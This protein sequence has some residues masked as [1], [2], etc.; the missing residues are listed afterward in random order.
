M[1]SETVLSAV[2]IGLLPA[3]TL[4]NGVQERQ[5]FVVGPPNNAVVPVAAA[6]VAPPP[7]NAIVEPV[8]PILSQVPPQAPAPIPAPALPAIPDVPAVPLSVPE[9]PPVP[10]AP[11]LPAPPALPVPPALPA[12]PEVPVAPSVPALPIVGGTGAP[13][14]LDAATNV[15]ANPAQTLPEVGNVVKAVDETH[16]VPSQVLNV[17]A[18]PSVVGELA[19][20]T[21][22]ASAAKNAAYNSALL[23][24]IIPAA[25]TGGLL[26]SKSLL[27]EIVPTAVGLINAPVKELVGDVTKLVGAVKSKVDEVPGALNTLVPVGAPLWNLTASLVDPLLESPS[28]STVY[29]APL[30]TETKPLEF[31]GGLKDPT[32]DK[33]CF[34]S[35][36]HDPTSDMN[37]KVTIPIDTGDESESVDDFPDA[38]SGFGVKMWGVLAAVGIAVVM[39][40]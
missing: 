33:P 26:P 16:V 27:S 1:R 38:A 36:C 30:P 32:L 6:I 17:A 3:S 35:S 12:V 20:V 19:N 9:L 7:N 18:A 39:G 28:S 40:L 4:A 21:D 29:S 25:M 15:L 37:Y 23:H 22:I 11:S 2:I 10:A 34:N 13:A 14:P 31:T 24:S 5:P 8:A